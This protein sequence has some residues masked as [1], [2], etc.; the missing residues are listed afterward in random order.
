MTPDSWSAAGINGW[1]LGTRPPCDPTSQWDSVECDFQG[2]VTVRLS[3]Q[4]LVG[5]LTQELSRLTQLKELLMWD[6][7]INGT[8]PAAFSVL[9]NL[10]YIVSAGATKRG[11]KGKSEGERAVGGII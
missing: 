1:T 10:Q 4:Q 7:M 3:S 8:L 5:T 9:A 2:L 11:G 6:N